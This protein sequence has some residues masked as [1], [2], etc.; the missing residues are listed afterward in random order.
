MWLHQ[1]QSGQAELRV[2][3]LLERVEEEGAVEEAA[4]AAEEEGA[5]WEGMALDGMTWGGMVWAGLSWEGIAWEGVK[6]ANS[7]GKHKSGVRRSSG[8]SFDTQQGVGPTASPFCN[9][10]SKQISRRRLAV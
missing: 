4:A 10:V 8:G 3:S 9:T 2:Y 1:K 6:K 7:F 5:G